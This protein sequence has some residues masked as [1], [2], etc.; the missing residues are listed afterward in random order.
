MSVINSAGRQSPSASRGLRLGGAIIALVL[1]VI[2]VTGLLQ[3]ARS[4][5]QLRGRTEANAVPTVTVIH[6]RPLG[7]AASL[8]LPGRLEAHSRAQI[9]ARAS[10]YLKSWNVDIGAQV[11]AG[12]LLAEIETP[13]L[14][15]QLAQ[16]RADLAKADADAALA[17]TTAQRWQSMRGTDAVSQQEVD[18]KSGDAVAK[19]AAVKAA[20]ANVERLLAMQ[21]FQH[22]VA[23]FDGI[24]IS[25]ATDIGALI[26]A[27]GGNGP[28]L[29]SVA[30]TRT[31][32]VYVQVP[33]NY[34]PSI[35]IGSA[36]KLSVP[37][38]PGRR[39]DARVESTAGAVIASSGGSLVQLAVDNA[40]GELLPGGYAEINIDLPA[41][42]EGLSIPA[43]SLV[44]DGNGTRVAV[45]DTDNTAR[46][47]PITIN[48][49]L[50]NSIEVL[51]LVA[52]DNVI[53][54]PPDSLGEGDA[55]QLAKAPAGAENND[56]PTVH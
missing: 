10:G 35:R 5:S 46:M 3:R 53:D 1:V 14:D 11:K 41:A 37:E 56:A 50:G 47:K 2:V 8:R 51:G 17:Q 18:E 39:F 45:L 33:Q 16:A 31:L 27:G 40:K 49:D 6:P 32:R 7:E 25:R 21:S 34:M 48:R 22:V 26:M 19:R 44:F 30:N 13:D 38:Y 12:Q 55:V 28:E 43:S 20:Q 29:F 4:S 42:T 23:P 24:V 15:Q 54:S 9:Y 52:S 36:A